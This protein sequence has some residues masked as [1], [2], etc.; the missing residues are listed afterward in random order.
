[1][2]D[3]VN[4]I[5]IVNLADVRANRL[6]QAG[7]NAVITS[8]VNVLTLTGITVASLKVG[9]FPVLKRIYPP[10]GVPVSRGEIFFKE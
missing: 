1:M 9:E 10:K 5:G 8:G 4:A 7:A 3:P 2:V 6:T